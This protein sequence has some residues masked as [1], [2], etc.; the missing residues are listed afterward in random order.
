MLALSGKI[1]PR[2]A[3]VVRLAGSSTGFTG[4][5]GLIIRAHDWGFALKTYR[6]LELAFGQEV[7]AHAAEAI[8]SA[9][10][11]I[12]DG[13]ILRP[14]SI[15]AESTMDLKAFGEILAH[16]DPKGYARSMLA[17]S[18]NLDSAES[19]DA[20][21]RTLLA[22]RTEKVVL[23][24]CRKM[25]LDRPSPM[26]AKEAERLAGV[27]DGTV[28]IVEKKPTIPRPISAADARWK[29]YGKGT[30]ITFVSTSSLVQGEG[31]NRKIVPKTDGPSGWRTEFVLEAFSPAGATFLRTETSIFA[32]ALHR[33]GHSSSN[34]VGFPT[35]S[36]F[37]P[38]P[39]AASSPPKN[40]DESAPK[41]RG[42]AGRSAG[43]ASDPNTS[44]NET[45]GAPGASGKET[46][47]LAGRRLECQ[48]K[49]TSVVRHPFHNNSVETVIT[50]I[51][52]CDEIPG[53]YVRATQE[54]R[55]EFDTRLV[56]EI[57]QSF[58]PVTK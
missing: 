6:R 26:S 4:R 47:Q 37:F 56:E 46:L 55:G 10:R 48:W 53:G 17:F 52:T 19:I 21:Y 25:S 38:L 41:R 7:V 24:A 33:E 18:Q 44:A 50:R 16:G 57:L 11:R 39:R 5:S 13:L 31:A 12:S 43:D 2:T 35:G 14:E 29:E 34:E 23:D 54:T 20:A 40:S 22:G 51:W 28:K 30:R 49:E 36:I 45:A 1:H 58:E 15:G 42:T 32:P 9:P 27:I 8:A 3:I